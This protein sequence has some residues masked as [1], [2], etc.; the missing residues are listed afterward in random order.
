MDSGNLLAARRQ[1]H[2][3]VDSIEP[4][5]PGIVMVG[6]EGDVRIWSRGQVRKAAHECCHCGQRIP[7][8]QY[9]YRPVHNV[10]YRAQRICDPCVRAAIVD[11][12]N[13]G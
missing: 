9:A 5:V 1:A 6:Y 3:P 12:G 11:G 10:V 2:T 8:R 13:D 4:E 7:A